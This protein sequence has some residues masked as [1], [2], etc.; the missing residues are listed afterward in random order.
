[1]DKVITIKTTKLSNLRL[2]KNERHITSKACTHKGQKLERVENKNPNDT[3]AS[4]AFVLSTSIFL[5]RMR[6]KR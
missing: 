3:A 1:M 4:I 2:L 6:V 5:L